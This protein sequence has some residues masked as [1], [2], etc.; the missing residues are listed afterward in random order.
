[1]HI[2]DECTCTG[3]SL[4]CDHEAQ[5]L[6]GSSC[7]LIG[8]RHLPPPKLSTEALDVLLQAHRQRNNV[9]AGDSALREGGTDGGEMQHAREMVDVLHK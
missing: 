3:M 5:H 7:C 9:T 6:G 8:T 1:M 4:R 2:I